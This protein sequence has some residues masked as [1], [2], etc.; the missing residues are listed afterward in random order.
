MVIVQTMHSISFGG[1][2]I[3]AYCSLWAGVVGFCSLFFVVAPHRRCCLFNEVTPTEKA[4]LLVMGFY[5][6]QPTIKVAYLISQ[7]TTKR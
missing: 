6:L 7:L 1:K 3:N 2:T 4:A 5:N